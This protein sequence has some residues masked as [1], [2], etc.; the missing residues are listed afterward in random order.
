MHAPTSNKLRLALTSIA[1][2]LAVGTQTGNSQEEAIL[3]QNSPPKRHTRIPDAS[4]IEGKEVEKLYQAL[5]KNLQTGFALSGDPT[6]VNYQKW[7][8]Y[9]RVAFRSAGHGRRFVSTYAN[10]IA[11]AYGKYERAGT[12]P[13]GSIIAKDSIIITDDGRAELGVLAIMEKMPE[14]FEYVTGNWKY[15][16][17]R[18]DGKILGTTNGKDSEHV[19]YC[20][21][22]HLIAEDHDHLR[23]M[24]EKFRR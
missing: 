14:G 11:K 18:S 17:I 6:A 7:Q 9:N 10:E 2:L 8:R 20:I 19:E 22:C 3:A 5:R 12:L 1:L 23:F 13:V 15:S 4:Y 24:P 16:E 21:A